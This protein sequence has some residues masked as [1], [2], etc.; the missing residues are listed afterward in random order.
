MVSKTL[1]QG[2]LTDKSKWWSSFISGKG[3]CTMLFYAVESAR[4]GRYRQRRNLRSS[5]S[6]K[7]RA[8]MQRMNME[9]K[10]TWEVL[11]EIHK[12]LATQSMEKVLQIEKEQRATAC[13]NNL[14][15]FMYLSDRFTFGWSPFSMQ[16]KDERDCKYGLRVL[17][18]TSCFPHHPTS[19]GFT[20]RI[21]QSNV[22]CSLRLHNIYPT[23][24]R[25]ASFS[26][27]SQGS[28]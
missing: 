5:T 1:Y 11:Q 7:R 15:P 24:K 12:S 21:S 8:N 9:K 3:I 22:E 17:T 4:N 16:N 23:K 18:D 28:C 20:I 2:M 10:D 13:P 6:R 25:K 14:R 27:H 19:G 26:Q